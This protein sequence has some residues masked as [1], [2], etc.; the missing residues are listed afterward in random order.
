MPVSRQDALEPQV[1]Q[2]AALFVRRGSRSAFFPMQGSAVLAQLVTW[3][4]LDGYQ[5]VS[6]GQKGIIPGLSRLLIKD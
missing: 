5:D 1:G 3:P 4:D 2:D 6:H